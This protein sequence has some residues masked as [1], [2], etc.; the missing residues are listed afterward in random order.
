VAGWNMC[1]I[2]DRIRM[3]LERVGVA[4]LV[5]MALDQGPLRVRLRSDGLR[6]SRPVY[7]PRTD[8]LGVWR[9]VSK[10]PKASVTPERTH[11]WFEP[12][13]IHRSSR[14]YFTGTGEN[15]SLQSCR[16]SHA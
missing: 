16:R 1:L 11:T 3:T 5:I 9:Q 15:G 2:S 10:V 14:C 7:P 12:E 6:T 8:V 4:R 13:T